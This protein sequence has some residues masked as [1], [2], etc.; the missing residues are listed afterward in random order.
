MAYLNCMR[1]ADAI[2]AALAS[3]LG[4]PLVSWDKEHVERASTR[5]TVYTP[6]TAPLA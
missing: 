4:V 2:Y 5:V 6:D 1:G 3:T